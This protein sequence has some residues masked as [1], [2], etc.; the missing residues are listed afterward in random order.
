MDTGTDFDTN[1]GQASPL[2]CGEL[3]R[4]AIEHV[5]R[6]R[7]SPD[8]RVDP[9][10]L[11]HVVLCERCSEAVKRRTGYLRLITEVRR[12]DG[13]AT[14]AAVPAIVPGLAP[15]P[16]YKLGAELHRGGQG[17]VYAAEQLATRRRCAVKTLIGG[18]F[19]SPAQRQ[20]FEREVEV[21]A[22]LRH[23]GIVTLYESGVSRDGEPWFAMELVDGERLDAFVSRTTPTPR[24]LVQLFRRIAEAVAYAH[25]RGIIHR[26]LKPGNIL[27][28][29]DGAPRVLDFG[30]ARAE[31]GADRLDHRSDSTRA[32]EFVGTFAYAA[33]EQLSNDPAGID[34]RCDLYALG[35]V[36]YESL[37]GG[38]PFGAAK[39]LA[40][41][42]QL[43]STGAI[44]RPSEAASRRGPAAHAIDR[45]IDVIVLRLLAADPSRRYDTADALVEDLERY[46]DGR[47][48]LA[49]EDSLAYVV[50][51]TVRRHWIV[52]T[53]AA[54]LFLTVV[55]AGISLAFAYR[56][57]ES[58]RVRAEGERVRVE[59]AYRSFREALEQADP[60]LGVGT[61]EMR[62]NDFLL[63]V[64]RQV[65]AEL[66]NEPE[67]L[68]EILQT[69][70]LI[71]LGFDESARA[72]DAIFRSY[73]LLKRGH[74]LGRV[75]DIQQASA[76]TAL[77]KLRFA[78]DDF[79]GAEA[80]YLE[81][82]DLRTKALG[83]FAVETVDT[84]R[85]LASALREQGKYDEAYQRLE[86]AYEHAAR[87]PSQKAA[88]LAR[89]GILN[90]KG[91]LALAQED[92]AL[93]IREFQAA[94]D[95]ISPHVA[96]DDFRIGRSLFSLARSELGI[97]RSV[98]AENHARRAYEILK[99]RKGEGAKS[100]RAARELLESIEKQR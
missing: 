56:R 40:E 50:S 59:R 74:E 42:V 16:G 32:G 92:H 98:D 33:P 21:V 67:L 79:V 23:P 37:T 43:K 77:A 57:A 58:E 78:K 8:I 46:L 53:L 72:S 76:A 3:P 93:A 83:A 75:T 38:P 100:T 7:I 90:G 18:R 19:A 55:A 73:E 39:S 9:N 54:G 22:G 17:T 96:P 45:D 88:D 84:E 4:D 30:L 14:E 41:L 49:R 99:L 62:V 28:D 60:E 24:E 11:A 2:G 66:V 82:L 71:Q 87:F 29:R 20:R 91:V 5:A 47:P 85:Q 26:D 86:A 51:K 64:E 61:S 63:I 69:L 34:S 65:R 95:A 31:I 13:A 94:I 89:A 10:V 36:M 15:I 52:S 27:I 80:A 12:I 81:A 68:A 25:R 70:G 48:I 44:P 1:D 97:G 35:V 6:Y